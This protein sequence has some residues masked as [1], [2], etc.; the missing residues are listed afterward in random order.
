MK[1][2][3]FLTIKS[4]AVAV[5]LVDLQL[6]ASIVATLLVTSRLRLLCPIFS[7]AH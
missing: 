3:L 2:N 4:I 1:T 5:H 6:A 7:P